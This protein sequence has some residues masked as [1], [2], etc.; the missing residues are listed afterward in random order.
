M[1]HLLLPLSAGLVA[2]AAP[3]QMSGP[4]LIDPAAAGAFASFTE[5]VNALF[6]NG[7]NGPVDIFV[8]PG[9]YTESVL[10][11]P[12]NGASSTNTITFQ[13]I[14]TPGS[15]TIQGGGGDIF[16]MLGVAFQHNRSVVWDGIHFVGANG[17]AISGTTWVEDMEV[18]NCYFSG[19]HRS[20]AAGEYRHAVIVSENSTGQLGWRVH[21]NTITLATYTNRSSYGIYLSNGG[22]WEIH[23]NTIDCNGGDY[24]LYLINNNTTLDKIYN[25]LFVGTLHQTTSTS[26]GQ[27]AIKADVSNYNNQISHNTFAMTLPDNACAISSGSTTTQSNFIYGN[28]FYL[29]GGTAIVRAVIG[30]TSN[31]ISDGNVF[32]CPGGNVG[33]L[34]AS[35]TGTPYPTLLDWQLANG[36][37]TASFEGDPLLVDPFGAVPDLRPTP[38]SPIAGVAVNT[39]S[40]VTDDFAGRL[41]DA[42]PDAGAYESTSFALFGQGCAGTGGLI[43]ALGNSGTAQLGSTNFAFELTQTQPI[44]IAV[45]FGGLSQLSLP[46][47]GTCELLA[48]PDATVVL[49]TDAAGM[50]SA[51][52]P[53]PN[54][55]AL[56]GAN[57]YFQI[58][59]S[60]TGSSSP[61][62]LAFTEG[63]ALQF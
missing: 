53:I 36:V 55:S 20:T 24:G 7:V 1:K 11:P 63:G 54:N 62:G 26:I 31:I 29:I 6:V 2:V 21:H 37:D 59:V 17:H 57:L 13:P 4:Y 16:A 39:P 43:P 15:V 60:D 50:A 41:R 22:N 23:H 12:I 52:F 58:A 40:W 9:A 14:T 10:F 46:L 42:N 28:V 27:A 5:A 30:S 34:N 18:R 25:N 51:P 32:F 61:L 47:G 45:L 8:A 3:A 38:S 33:R 44:S 48:S 19:D 35:S 49:V 56:S